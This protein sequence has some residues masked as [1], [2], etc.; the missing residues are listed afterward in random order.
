V[1]QAQQQQ[2]QEQRQH[3]EQSLSTQLQKQ[4]EQQ[5]DAQHH[6]GV[7]NTDGAASKDKATGGCCDVRMGNNNRH[8]EKQQQQQRDLQC[9]RDTAR[10]G[11]SQRICECVLV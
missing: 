7:G 4:K 1:S 5:N 2:Q 6:D 3:Q 10:G 11:K 8:K 9:T